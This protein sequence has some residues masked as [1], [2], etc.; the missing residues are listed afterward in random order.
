[1]V[2]DYI[3]VKYYWHVFSM[4]RFSA[5]QVVCVCVRAWVGELDGDIGSQT[6]NGQSTKKQLHFLFYL[7][8]GHHH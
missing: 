1:M 2:H 6:D 5:C 8:G 7:E 3:L 4:P